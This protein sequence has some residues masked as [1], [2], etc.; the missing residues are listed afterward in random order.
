ML[1]AIGRSIGFPDDRVAAIFSLSALL[2]AIR[3]PPRKGRRRPALSDK[4]KA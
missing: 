2:W 3:K 1:P 4:A